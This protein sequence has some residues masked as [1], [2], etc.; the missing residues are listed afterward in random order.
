MARTLTPSF[1]AGSALLK[2]F[3]SSGQNT[4]SIKKASIPYLSKYEDKKY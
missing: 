2:N 3:A 1:G 4:C